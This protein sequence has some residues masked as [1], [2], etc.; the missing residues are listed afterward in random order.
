MS[1]VIAGDLLLDARSARAAAPP[2]QHLICSRYGDAHVSF[3]SRRGNAQ[4]GMLDG[5][6]AIVTGA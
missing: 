4:M 6:V 5:K 3:L 2:W 1:T